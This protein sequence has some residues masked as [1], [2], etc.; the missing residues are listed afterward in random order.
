M[1]RTHKNRCL[2][3]QKACT[4]R[5]LEGGRLIEIGRGSLAQNSRS[6]DLFLREKGKETS[7]GNII[8]RVLQYMQVEIDYVARY[9]AKHQDLVGQ[10]HFGSFL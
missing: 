8:M 3:Y 9:E 1:K 7:Q 10:E 6:R 5:D 4:I 2:N